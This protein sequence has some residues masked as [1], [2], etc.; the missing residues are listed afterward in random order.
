MAILNVKDFI[1]SFFSAY[2]CKIK[3]KEAGVLEVELTE[4]LDK[5][6]MN[7]PFYWHYVKSLGEEG[8]PMNLT[9]ITAPEK[10]NLQGEWIDI[11]TP[12]FQQMVQHITQQEKYVL[13]FQEVHT[14]QN[15]PLY[16][17][18]LANIKISYRGKQK[19]EE[20]ISLGIQLI[21]GKVVVN[22]MD[23]LDKLSLKQ[24]ISNLCYT[25]S[26]L[27]TLNSGYKRLEKIILEYI[28][29]EP[30]D[31]AVEAMETLN[32]EIALLKEFYRD[33]LENDLFKKEVEELNKRYSPEIKIEV[34]NGGFL[35]LLDDFSFH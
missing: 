9:F 15:T 22:M 5:A 32:K 28:E 16:P 26:P 10:R 7:R 6:L 19:R 14:N 4:E 31:W 8:V 29:R 34:S 24:Q 3:E 11:G 1:E 2:Q 27:I 33:D 30:K 18:L 17:W 21:S 35:Y 25:L 12:R 13:L 23:E 20:L